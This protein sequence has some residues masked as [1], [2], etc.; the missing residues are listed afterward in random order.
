MASGRASSSAGSRHIDEARG[1]A[2]QPAVLEML[3]RAGLIEPFL[4]AGVRI[5]HI[6]LLGPGLREIVS[7]DFADAGCAYEFQCSLPQW[8]TEAIL[9]EHLAS[10]GLQIEFGTEVTSIEDDPDGVRVTLDAG[11][12]T[13]TVTAAYVLGAGGGHSVTRHSMQEHLAGETYDGRYF[14]AD[15]KVQPSCAAGMRSPRCGADRV[16]YCS[17][18]CRMT[19]G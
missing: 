16:S 8:R 6:Q 5:R 15:A 3:E 17:R 13:E 18:R 12:R 1:T 4:R 19:A 14:V 11:G 9:R 7:E 2:L 10:L